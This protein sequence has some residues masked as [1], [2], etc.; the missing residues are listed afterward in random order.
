VQGWLLLRDVTPEL[1]SVYTA[2]VRT[3]L[4]NLSN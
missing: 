1:E 3:Q 2:Q 4:T